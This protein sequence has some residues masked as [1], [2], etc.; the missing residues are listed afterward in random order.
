MFYIPGPAAGGIS[1]Y[2]DR[3]RA[4][5]RTSDA[6]V[7]GVDSLWGH[8]YPFDATKTTFIEGIVPDNFKAGEDANLFVSCAPQVLN[9]SGSEKFVEI[10]TTFYTARAGVVGAGIITPAAVLISIPDNEAAK[11]VHHESVA[12]V[13]GLQ[14]GDSFTVRIRRTAA[15]PDDTYD[16]DF[17]IHPLFILKYVADKLGVAV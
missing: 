10:T 3:A 17:F 6:T 5:F 16:H 7:G 14:A 2:Y 4:W 8:N 11:T 13:A 15:D 12:V 1:D 9:D